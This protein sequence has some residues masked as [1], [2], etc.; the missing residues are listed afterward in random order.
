MDTNLHTPGDFSDAFLLP[1][2]TY[3]DYEA[4]THIT[5]LSKGGVAPME[6][7]NV[8]VN[9]AT[10]ASGQAKAPNLAIDI[11]TRRP[12]VGEYVEINAR[13]TDGNASDYAYSWFVNEVPEMDSRVL[14]QP[15]LTKSFDKAGEYV[16]RAVVSDMKGGIASKNLLLQVGEYHYQPKSTISGLVGSGK[17]EIQGARVVVEPAPIIEHTVSLAGS[18]SGSYL[19]NANNEPLHYLINGEKAPDLTFRRGEV[20]RFTFDSTTDGFPL[21]L[22][23]HPEHEMPKVLS[24]IHI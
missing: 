1:G 10:I 13:V 3:S 9:L 5:T 7:L 4:D 2:F 12:S 14:N 20:H 8:V 16:I 18:I 17:G 21:S 6:Y 15:T 22:F 19:P 11:N 23:R 24:L